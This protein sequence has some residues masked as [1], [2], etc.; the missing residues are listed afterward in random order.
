MEV[1]RLTLHVLAACLLLQ[2]FIVLADRV[3]H[4]RLHGNL[5]TAIPALGL[6]A[7]ALWKG[8]RAHVPVRGLSRWLA[9]LLWVAPFLFVAGNFCGHPISPSIR[10]EVWIAIGLLCLLVGLSEELLFRGYFFALL[11]HVNPAICLLVVSLIFGI[12]H[13]RLGTQGLVFAGIIGLSFGLARLAG[14]PLLLLMLLHALIDLPV[15]LPQTAG[16]PG[17]K[18]MIN[19]LAFKINTHSGLLLFLFALVYTIVL[20]AVFIVHQHPI[21]QRV[22]RWAWK[23]LPRRSG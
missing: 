1:I 15:L 22:G 11:R 4:D 6:Q 2:A 9:I 21:F 12:F 23:R 3:T 19:L 5:I 10:I 14:M 8:W 16:V 13:Y 7:F 17:E 18:V 20:T